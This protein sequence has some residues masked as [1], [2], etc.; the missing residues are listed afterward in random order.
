MIVMIVSE[1]R[2]HQERVN[3]EELYLGVRPYGAAHGLRPG[4]AVDANIDGGA[5]P[6]NA[7]GTS[8][9]Q[10]DVNCETAAAQEQGGPLGT[11]FWQQYLRL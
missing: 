8:F 11:R 7:L 1:V 5:F 10:A 4:Q 9:G 3:R 2:L 6:R